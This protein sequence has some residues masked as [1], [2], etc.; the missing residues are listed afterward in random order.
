MTVRPDDGADNPPRKSGRDEGRRRK[1]EA[2]D[3]HEAH[4]ARELLI[5]QR[6]FCERLLSH[7]LASL[8]DL[9]QPPW[10]IGHFLGSVHRPFSNAGMIVELRMVPN[11]RPICKGRRIIEWGLVNRAAI[12]AWQ[13]AN[14][15]PPAA[16]VNSRQPSLPGME[17]VHDG[18]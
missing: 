17:G 13:T 12:E 2:L 14:P 18:N 7:G 1:D 5:V 4:H 16:P 15:V 6:Q 11:R 9:D 3:G 10:L 8:N